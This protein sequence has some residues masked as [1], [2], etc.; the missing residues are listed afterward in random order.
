MKY[1]GY[2]IPESNDN[3]DM[4]ISWFFD[5]LKWRQYSLDHGVP[6]RIEFDQIKS[7]RSV[8]EIDI[9]SDIYF[10]EVVNVIDEEYI[11]TVYEKKKAGQ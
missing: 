1:H 3:I 9:E 7:L 6:K 8:Y 5:T 10:F 4:C 2:E 11:Q